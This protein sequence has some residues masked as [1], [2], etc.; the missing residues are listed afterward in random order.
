MIFQNRPQFGG[1]VGRRRTWMVRQAQGTSKWAGCGK[2]YRGKATK[3]KNPAFLN[4]VR[5]NA[6]SR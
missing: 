3:F 6:T 4:F 1:Q 2:L 5:K